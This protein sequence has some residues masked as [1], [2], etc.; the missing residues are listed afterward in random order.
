MDFLWFLFQY[1]MI[2]IKKLNCLIFTLS[3]SQKK[4]TH[5]RQ[6]FGVYST[7]Q[8]SLTKQDREI[9]RCHN[10]AVF[11]GETFYEDPETKHLVITHEAH[12]RRKKCCGSAC[13]HVS[14]P[15]PQ[16]V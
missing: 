8:S 13:R 3:V 15:F 6:S 10:R 14:R 4:L 11:L 12:V 7:N 5:L 2:P 16:I 9:I 1:W